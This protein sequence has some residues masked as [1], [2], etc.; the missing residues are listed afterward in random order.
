MG[1]DGKMV[2]STRTRA[3]DGLYVENAFA[4]DD[5]GQNFE[6]PSLESI[7]NAMAQPEHPEIPRRGRKGRKGAS[8]SMINPSGVGDSQPEIAH[9]ETSLTPA[10]TLQVV[11]Q[12]VKRGTSLVLAF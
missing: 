5:S 6:L 8:K 10:L 9:R 11:L 12:R 7:E 4:D 3:S 2:V 1:P